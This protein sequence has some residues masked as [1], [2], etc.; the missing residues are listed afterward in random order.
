MQ[1]LRKQAN[2]TGKLLY[3]NDMKKQ[4]AIHREDLGFLYKGKRDTLRI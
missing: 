3:I 2:S 4:N 1:Y